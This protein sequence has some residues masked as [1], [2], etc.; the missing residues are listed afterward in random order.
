MPIIK[1]CEKCNQQA[2]FPTNR[3]RICLK[4]QAV[5]LA[6]HR[7]Q[8]RKGRSSVVREIGRMKPVRRVA[9]DRVAERHVDAAM[10]A[11]GVHSMLR[12]LDIGPSGMVRRY[13]PGDSGFDQL[14]AQ[15]GRR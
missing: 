1:L 10:V 14:A 4:C 12:C 8:Q 2:E 11:A 15:Y 5:N 3:H 13:R 7:V 6:E 9:P